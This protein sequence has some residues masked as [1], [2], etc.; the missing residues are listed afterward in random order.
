[1][2]TVLWTVQ[3][4]IQAVEKDF[5]DP[6]ENT[7]TNNCI[8]ATVSTEINKQESVHQGHILIRYTNNHLVSVGNSIKG[9]TRYKII[10]EVHVTEYVN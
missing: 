5:M 2:W 3:M 7:D 4:M 10:K 9:D 8:L 6:F 1:M